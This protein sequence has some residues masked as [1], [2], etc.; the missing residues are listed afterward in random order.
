[1]V[2]RRSSEGQCTEGQCLLVR[3]CFETLGQDFYPIC[4]WS[5]LLRL[6]GLLSE[7]DDTNNEKR[8][9]LKEP[10]ALSFEQPSPEC[11]SIPI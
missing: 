2:R 4:V 1:M 9:G 10:G 3:S 5:R 7:G 8:P 6:P 11:C